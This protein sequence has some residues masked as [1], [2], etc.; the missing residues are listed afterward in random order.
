MNTNEK[1]SFKENLRTYCASLL[2][3]RLNNARLAMEDAQNSAN[4]DTKSSAGDKH[5]TGRAMSQLEIEMNARLLNQVQSELDLLNAIDANKVITLASPGA[6]ICA[7]ELMFFIAVGLGKCDFEGKHLIVL[8]AQSPIAGILKSKRVGE[9]FTFNG[10]MV[11]IEDI[12]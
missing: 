11:T 4:S 5:E 10:K 9:Q 3:K 1:I 2:K 12:Y 8:S 6:V 7:G